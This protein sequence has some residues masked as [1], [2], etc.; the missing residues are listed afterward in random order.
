MGTSD[1]QESVGVEIEDDSRLIRQYCCLFPGSR[2][3]TLQQAKQARQDFLQRHSAPPNAIGLACS[4]SLWL[5]GRRVSGVSDHLS[6]RRRRE[7]S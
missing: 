6:S 4:D 5:C 7:T 2:A 1:P 3:L